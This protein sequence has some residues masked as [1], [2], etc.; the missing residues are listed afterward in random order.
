MLT[1]SVLSTVAMVAWL[2]H[3]CDGALPSAISM[4][5]WTLT[6][7]S[8]T[9]GPLLSVTSSRCALA[10][11]VHVESALARAGTAHA[12]APASA[13]P[14]ATRWMGFMGRVSL[15]VRRDGERGGAA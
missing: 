3:R 4:R 12:A 10:E 6:I 9:N 15:G 2:K 13:T 11:Y 1:V 7:R 14:R 5:R 8:D